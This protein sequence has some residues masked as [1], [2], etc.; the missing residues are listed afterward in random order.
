M[1]TVVPGFARF[2]ARRRL[3]RGLSMVPEFESLP[4]GETYRVEAPA[5]A[6]IRTRQQIAAIRMTDNLA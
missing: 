6:L 1:L 2:A 4:I 5:K 3:L